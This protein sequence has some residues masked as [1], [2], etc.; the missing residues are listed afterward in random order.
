MADH[1]AEQI[2][3]AVQALVSGLVTT[4]TN[5]DRGREEEIPADKTPALRVRQGADPIVDPWAQA[6]LDSDLDVVIEAKVHSSAS[7][8]ETLLNQ[9]RKEV[10][11]A[12]V[13]NHTLGLAFVHAIVELGAG[14][15]RITG[16]LAKPAASMELQYRVKYRRSRGD[17]SA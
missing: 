3:A 14:E 15:P 13:A 11:I 17:P 2:M 1:R 16:E 12:L 7:N 8:V 9:V 6:L 4:G 5:V 10:N